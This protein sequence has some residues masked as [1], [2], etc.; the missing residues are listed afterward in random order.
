MIT[1]GKLLSI[2]K[3]CSGAELEIIKGHI[4]ATGSSNSFIEL[5]ARVS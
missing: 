2:I 4:K 3:S 5:L 1:S